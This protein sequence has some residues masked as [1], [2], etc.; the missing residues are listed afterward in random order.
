[1]AKRKEKADPPGTASKRSKKHSG[2]KQ[3][4]AKASAATSSDE[5]PKHS[6]SKG[7]RPSPNLSSSSSESSCP[8]VNDEASDDSSSEAEK[9][10]DDKGLAD[11]R[12]TGSTRNLQRDPLTIQDIE[13]ISKKVFT[14]KAKRYGYLS[15]TFPDTN[16]T[17]NTCINIWMELRGRQYDE[18]SRII[19][20]HPVRVML[21]KAISGSRSNAATTMRRFVHNYDFTTG[22]LPADRQ[23][24]SGK[25]FRYLLRKSRFARAN[26]DT[27]GGPF[28]NQCLAHAMYYVFYPKKGEARVRLAP[29]PER[30]TRGLIVLTYT[31]LY[32]SM[33]RFYGHKMVKHDVD[34]EFSA[35]S[36][37]KR[38]YHD[39]MF[40]ASGEEVDWKKVIDV[41]QSFLDSIVRQDT[42]NNCINLFDGSSSDT[43]SDGP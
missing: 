25:Q 28:E 31:L 27:D 43:E 1:M 38:T 13:Q 14:D 30:I 3:K 15:N 6:Q 9:V 39:F 8:A 42:S 10:T 11:S 22:N 19:V 18:D 41:Q 29:F 16:E 37:W 34:K 12:K 4:K 5:N 7:P 20:A 2:K 24:H 35:K 36:R 23:E 33:A 26:F 21:R 40:G 17:T 32:F